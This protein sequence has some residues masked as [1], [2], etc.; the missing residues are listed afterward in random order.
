MGQLKHKMTLILA[1]A[2]LW[3]LG[4][5]VTTWLFRGHEAGTVWRPPLAQAQPEEPVWA[6]SI[7]KL[8]HHVNKVRAGK[9]MTPKSWP[10]G[11]RV[12]VGL[13]FDFDTEPVWLGSLGQFSPGYMARG[14]YCARVGLDRVLALLDKHAIPAT[15]F[16]QGATFYLHEDAVR[17]VMQRPQH[18]IGFHS[19][20]H[21]NPMSLTEA[22]EREVYAKATAAF[23]QFTGKAPVGIRTAAWD[24]TDNTLK[25]IQEF[26]FLY[27][28][29]LMADDRPYMLLAH[30]QETGLIE[31]PVEW[32]L[33]DWP[34]F[35]LNWAAHHVAIRN[36]ED[37]F[38][39]WSDEFDG[40]YEE[41]TSFI[42]TMHP[43]VIGHRYRMMMLDRLIQHMKSKP[44]VWFATHEQIARYALTQEAKQ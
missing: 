36:G 29:S 30:G 24:F 9:D 43:Q 21:E 34:L 23:K 13:S 37:V 28:S 8:Q 27:D 18:E 42:L 38:K 14:Q 32:I 2:L 7:E 16:W 20:V 44:G 17:K 35:Q 1:V 26:G 11:A 12:A 4:A 10:N 25:L 33:D 40:A 41:G 22:Q 15:F 31:L 39:L 6:W 19:W 3:T 5:L